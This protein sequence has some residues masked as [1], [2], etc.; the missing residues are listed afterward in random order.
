M[1][2]KFNPKSRIFLFALTFFLILLVIASLNAGAANFEKPQNISK[3]PSRLDTEPAIAVDKNNKVHIV[4]NAYYVKPGAPDNVACDIFYIHNKTGSFITPIKI[5]VPTG[6]YSREPAIAVD[7]EGNAHIVFRRSVDQLYL[8]SEDDIYYVTSAG[9]AL[10]RPLL[11]VDGKSGFPGPTEVC[12]PQSPLIHCDGQGHLYLAFIANQIGSHS[13][14]NYYLIYMNN[15]NGS[16]TKPS[17][18]VQGDYI[19]EYDSYLDKNGILHLVYCDLDQSAESRVFYSCN[20]RGSFSKPILASAPEHKDSSESKIAIDSKG[21]VHIVYRDWFV[22]M[23]TPDLFYV[24]NKSGG[25]KSWKSLC[26][27]DVYYIPSISIDE[28]DIVHITYKSVP[29]FGGYLYYGN[30]TSGDFKFR[31]VD[32]MGGSDWYVGSC[33]FTSGRV[34]TLHL[35][36]DNWTG[37]VDNSDS[38]IFY[39]VGSWAAG[40]Q[41][42]QTGTVS[43]SSSSV[44]AG[45]SATFSSTWLDANGSSD[46][47]G[48]FFLIGTGLSQAKTIYLYYEAQNN[49]LYLRSQ[50]GTKWMGGFA[51]G[52]ARAIQNSQVKLDCKKTKVTKSGHEVTLKWM[53]I[54]KKS[55]AGNKNLYLKAT[56]LGDLSSDWQK[57]G[58]VIITR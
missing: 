57:K 1:Q 3:N 52:S 6:W 23:G 43:P 9:G 56:D 54:F 16:W 31:L 15:K 11:L 44:K 28:S 42:P 45:V 22:P 32:D 4:W 14:E 13:A 27:S 48:C 39:R 19:S 41:A 38:E 46:L 36:F 7:S 25:F 40:P 20:N 24:T 12:K 34:C 18:A 58:T 49:K 26:T 53:L 29:A 2:K 17:L 37:E 55:Y 51:P 33:Y 47:K 50:D 21:K 30:N 5:T 35:A 8:R 10:N